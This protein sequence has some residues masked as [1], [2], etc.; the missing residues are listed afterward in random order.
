MQLSGELNDIAVTA[1]KEAE[2]LK[3]VVSIEQFW[4]DASLAIIPQMQ[5]E[6]DNI[7]VLGKVENEENISKIDDTLLTLNNI[8]GSRYS[9]RIRD[10]VEKQMKKFRYLQ[11]FLDEWF[12][13]QRNWLYLEVPLNFWFLIFLLHY[14]CIKAD[15]DLVSFAHGTCEGKPEVFADWCL[16]EKIHVGCVF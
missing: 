8:L 10:R 12:L 11:Q 4:I 6:K 7:Y 13:H 2:L 16:L 14:Y 1:A 9:E 3:M 15:F 5:R